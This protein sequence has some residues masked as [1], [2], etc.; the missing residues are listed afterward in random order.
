MM[1]DNSDEAVRD[2][3]HAVLVDR[4]ERIVVVRELFQDSNLR[5]L[6]TTAKLQ[7]GLDLLEAD[8]VVIRERRGVVAF[9]G[10]KKAELQVDPAEGTDWAEEIPDEEEEADK[11][12]RK[13][14]R[15]KE[16][17]SGSIRKKP[18]MTLAW[19]IK[20]FGSKHTVL[21]I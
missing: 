5:T 17:K 6:S 16:P 15:A 18:T 9:T 7:K 12:P 13:R 14:R 8:G 10:V 11:P 1:L 4:A 19:H 3:I 2:H 20:K 21:L